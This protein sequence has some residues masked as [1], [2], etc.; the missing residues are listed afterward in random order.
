MLGGELAMVVLYG[1]GTLTYSLR[2]PHTY[3]NAS[4]CRTLPLLSCRC[5]CLELSKPE[6]LRSAAPAVTRRDV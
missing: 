2:I 5:R 3:T 1:D 6:D 4:S